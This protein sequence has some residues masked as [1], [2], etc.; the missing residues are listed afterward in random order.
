MAG[1]MR[2][3]R[4]SLG[5]SAFGVAILALALAAAGLVFSVVNAVLLRPFPFRDPERLVLIGETHR[6]RP[7]AIEMTS[8]SNFIDY[9]DSS[10]LFE[11]AAA[12]QRPTSMTLKSAEGAE[13]IPASI[14]TAA[15]S[16]TG[17]SYRGK[18]GYANRTEDPAI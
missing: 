2:L 1:I 7:Q 6:D 4:K 16:S 11:G 18:D 9:T 13:E 12:W 3:S 14:V 8:F 5:G 17:G 10:R 15:D